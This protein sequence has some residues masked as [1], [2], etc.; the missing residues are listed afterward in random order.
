M[1][2]TIFKILSNSQESVSVET[3]NVLLNLIKHDVGLQNFLS[4][5]IN[6]FAISFNNSERQ[7]FAMI[8]LVRTQN[9]PKN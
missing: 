2:T 1:L 4:Q 6:V 5:W 9:F 7:S 3:F 8:H